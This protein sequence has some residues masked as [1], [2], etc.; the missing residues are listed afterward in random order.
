M[1]EGKVDRTTNETSVSVWVDL[2]GK[3]QCTVETGI[4]FFDHML[5]QVATHGI[6]DLKV[7]ATGDLAVD[8]HHTVEDVGISLGQAIKQALGE[9]KGIHRCGSC[10]M[11]M[12][13]ALAFVA[14]DLS[15][16]PYWIIQ[17]RWT[18]QV[19]GSVIAPQLPVTLVEHFFQTLAVQGGITLHMRLESG[20]DDHHSCEA[21][22][23][24]FARALD[25]ATRIDPKRSRSIP[26]SKGV[27]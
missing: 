19:L 24:A 25:E 11:P 13:E 12:D 10:F 1:R 5:S 23:K 7:K 2:D 15:N 22:F 4:P 27:L 14:L 20:R 26:S 17:I 21:L 8:A 6:I 9:K 18:G 16:R 3:G